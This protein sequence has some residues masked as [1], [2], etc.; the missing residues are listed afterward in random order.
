VRALRRQ[1]EISVKLLDEERCRYIDE[2]QKGM[3]RLD[4]LA[5]NPIRSC[6]CLVLPIMPSTRSQDVMEEHIDSL[7]KELADAM[8]GQLRFKKPP[9]WHRVKGAE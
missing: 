4:E 7:Y 8:R 3:R 1:I 5:A 6:G 9:L 2:L